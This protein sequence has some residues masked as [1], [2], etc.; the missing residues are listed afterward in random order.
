MGDFFR[1]MLP[2]K[3]FQ[4]LCGDTIPDIV[5]QKYHDFESEGLS[6]SSSTYSPVEIAFF[7]NYKVNALLVLPVGVTS[8]SSQ[9]SFGCPSAKSNGTL[10]V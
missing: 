9:F 8:P 6:P 10:N 4:T 3:K 7:S 2:P 1:V 5:V